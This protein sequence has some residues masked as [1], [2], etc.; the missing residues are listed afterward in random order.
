MFRRQANCPGSNDVGSLNRLDNSQAGIETK[1]PG[2]TAVRCFPDQH[3]FNRDADSEPH[4]L[5]LTA[6]CATITAR[7]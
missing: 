6:I 7:T 3:G 2:Q 4:H 1:P 5:S